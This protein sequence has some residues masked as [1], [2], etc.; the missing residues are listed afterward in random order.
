M[1]T[2]YRFIVQADEHATASMAA[3]EFAD[4]LQEVDGVVEAVRSKADD[5]TMD[6]GTIVSVVATSGAALAIAQGVA[7]WLRARRGVS[8]VYERASGSESLKVAVQ[9]I[10]PDTAKRIIEKVRNDQ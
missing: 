9:G 1:D 2:S 7:A 6:L 3:V 5:Q 8:L 10:D 4:S